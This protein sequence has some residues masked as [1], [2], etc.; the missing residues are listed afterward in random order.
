MGY[1]PRLNYFLP[2]CVADLF[3]VTRTT[4]TRMATRRI[5]IKAMT[6]K[7]NI[8]VLIWLKNKEQNRLNKWYYSMCM[9]YCPLTDT[10]LDSNFND[11]VFFVVDCAPYKFGIEGWWEEATCCSLYDE[12]LRWA[13]VV[14]LR[15]QHQFCI[16]ALYIMYIYD[17][18]TSRWCD[19]GWLL[20]STLCS[21]EPFGKFFP[22][23]LE[24]VSEI[25][26]L[27]VSLVSN[28]WY[29]WLF[30]GMTSSALLKHK[31]CSYAIL[32]TYNE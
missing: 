10:V 30:D 3:C 15:E 21:C 22:W 31:L 4:G 29:K 26:E 32:K 17:E 1:F 27:F 18:N 5:M 14:N 9:T 12:S 8:H 20:F 23:M 25:G 28:I 24:K 16:R 13:S 2:D 19:V 7:A 6:I 11:R